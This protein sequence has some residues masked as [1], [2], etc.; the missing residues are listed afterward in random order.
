MYISIDLGRSTTRV[1]ST[2]DL[3][4]IHKVV[5]FPTD[6][7]IGKE[8]KSIT[9]AIY[10]VSDGDHIEKVALGIP[11]V[12]DK[13]KKKFVVS[14]NYPTLNGMAFTS[15]LPDS[16][17][18]TKLFV[19]NDAVLGGLGEGFLGAGKDYNIIAYLTLSTG[20][21]GARIEK[22]DEGF[23][24][25]NGEPGHHVIS[26][27]DSV[28]DKSGIFGTFESFCSGSY[29]ELRYR[30]K[31]TNIKNDRIWMEYAKH[32]SSGIINVISFWKPQVIVLGGGVSNS[33]EM[34]YPYLM[35]NL[36]KQNFFEIPEIKKSELSDDSGIYGGFILLK[37]GK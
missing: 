11:G 23:D 32:L 37:G 19:E 24:Y 14:A 35:E 21:G 20:V 2:L 31:P 27:K 13:D 16:L 26:E 28:A 1:A 34:F 15:L 30:E 4:K 22:T 6:T 8:I 29:F 3:E 25:I 18:N 12:L 5:K 7:N 36:R 9:D 33:F 17:K 10:D